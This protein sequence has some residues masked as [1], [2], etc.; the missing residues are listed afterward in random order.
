MA[1]DSTSGVTTQAVQD[2]GALGKARLATNFDT[3]MKLLTTQL[4]NQDPLSPLDSNQFTQ[5]LTQMT[6]VEQQIYSNDLLKQLITNTGS[7]IST[8]VSLIGREVKATSTDAGLVKGKA[9]WGYNLP[10][11]AQNVK[12]EIVDANNKLVHASNADDADR[13]AGDHTFTWNGKDLT[14]KQLA[15]GGPYT[16]R[17]TATDSKGATVTTST[18]VRGVVSGV[19]QSGGKSLITINGAKIPW[20]NVTSIK[21]VETTSTTSTSSSTS[22]SST[23]ANTNTTTQDTAA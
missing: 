7:G 21:Q 6:G 1:V 2:T 5:Q 14:G 3:F 22:T 12:F 9:E 10:R 15:D 17:I 20:E 23:S 19:E 13:T 16:L 18:F 4:K 11:E 8:A